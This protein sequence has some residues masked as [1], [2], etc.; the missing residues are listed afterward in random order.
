M[1]S[2]SGTLYGIFLPATHQYQI[3]GFRYFTCDISINSS[4]YTYKALEKRFYKK[5]KKK[6]TC[7]N[8]VECDFVI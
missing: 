6:R 8:L 2:F 4:I 3:I 5:M 7:R 1:L